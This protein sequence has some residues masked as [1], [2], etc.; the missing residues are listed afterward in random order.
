MSIHIP[1]CLDFLYNMFLVL[2]LRF[3]IN[4]YTVLYLKHVFHVSPFL[5]KHS[6]LNSDM[7]SIFCFYVSVTC[8]LENKRIK[9]AS[10]ISCKKAKEVELELTFNAFGYYLIVV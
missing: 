10:E 1:I 8:G 9:D 3:Y 2:L 5:R 6:V 4:C 7:L